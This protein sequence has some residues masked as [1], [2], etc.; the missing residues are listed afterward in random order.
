MPT[1]RATLECGGLPIRL[2]AFSVQVISEKRGFDVFAEL[3]RRFMSSERNQADPLPFR[4]LPL[5]MKPWTGNDEIGVIRVMLFGVAE[6]LPGS[7]RIFLIP[8]SRDVQI[9]NR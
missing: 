5:A 4:P 6:N 8:E 3:A 9:R 7:P 1:V 2:L